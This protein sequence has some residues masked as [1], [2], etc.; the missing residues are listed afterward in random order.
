MLI[1]LLLD[2]LIMGFRN[3]MWFLVVYPPSKLNIHKEGG[4]MYDNSGM[5]THPVAGI[6][7]NC[8]TYCLTGISYF[9]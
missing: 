8:M 2:V 5:L 1:H 7:N 9:R 4:M 3:I 6:E